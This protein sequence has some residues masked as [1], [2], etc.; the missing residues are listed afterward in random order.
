MGRRK[1]PITEKILEL[2]PEYLSKYPTN[3]SYSMKMLA[4]KLK[5]DSQVVSNAY[6]SNRH[7]IST[8]VSVASKNG[9]SLGNVKNTPVRMKNS[10]VQERITELERNIASFKREINL[11]KELEKINKKNQKVILK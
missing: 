3:L 1:N 4:D 11:L 8:V 5:V 9:Y 6:Y 7:K 2:L 10:V